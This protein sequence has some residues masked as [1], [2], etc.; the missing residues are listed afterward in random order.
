MKFQ[1]GQIVSH[2]STI[3]RFYINIVCMGSAQCLVEDMDKLISKE[4]HI[5]IF[6]KNYLLS[7]TDRSLCI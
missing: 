1:K 5:F 3:N 2:T 7:K 4:R 6:M